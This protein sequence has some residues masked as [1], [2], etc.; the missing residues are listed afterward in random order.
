MGASLVHRSRTDW[1]CSSL[2]LPI[3]ASQLQPWRFLVN[4]PMEAVHT[5]FKLPFFFKPQLPNSHYRSATTTHTPTPP[6][7]LLLSPSVPSSFF[8]QT[9]CTLSFCFSFLKPWLSSGASPHS[10]LSTL[11]KRQWLPNVKALALEAS[12][13]MQTP[14]ASP[15]FF[16][17]RSLRSTTPSP[18]PWLVK[19]RGYR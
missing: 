6:P 13:L 7:C 19:S 1:W 9:C 5:C 4:V 8:Q 18:E 14:E 3:S 17:K 12:S 15:H 11:P 16:L 10:H 2:P